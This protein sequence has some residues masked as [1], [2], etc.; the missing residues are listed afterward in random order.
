MKALLGLTVAAF[1][2][3]PAIASAAA[4]CTVTPNPAPAGSTVM[5]HADGV[6]GDNYLTV[7]NPSIGTQVFDEGFTD[8]ID[9]PVFLAT[10]G[11]YT[12]SLFHAHGASY[13]NGPGY[14]QCPQLTEI[15]Q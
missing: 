14:A 13:G 11:S 3:L 7:Y 5:F 4:N 2:A 1:M 8:P 9:Q 6:N 12:F 10:P 15:V